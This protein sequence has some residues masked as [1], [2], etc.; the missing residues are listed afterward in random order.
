MGD[1]PP[2]ARAD[3]EHW[4]TISSTGPAASQD[5]PRPVGASASD[6]KRVWTEAQALSVGDAAL[7]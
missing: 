2:I 5:S 1:L 4:T 7:N 6:V 3:Q